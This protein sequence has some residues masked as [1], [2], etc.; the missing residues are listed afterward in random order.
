MAYI[1]ETCGILVK[2][3]W[4]RGRFCGD[5]CA[6]RFSSLKALEKLRAKQDAQ[7]ADK[8]FGDSVEKIIKHAKNEHVLTSDPVF[9]EPQLPPNPENGLTPPQPPNPQMVVNVNVPENLNLSLR[10][11]KRG[12]TREQSLKL[13]WKDIEEIK[14]ILMEQFQ[15]RWDLWKV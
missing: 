2:T 9:K 14:K 3:V 10:F 6:K 4:G 8:G 13:Q 11:R 5:R 15:P 1:C 7:S 12:K